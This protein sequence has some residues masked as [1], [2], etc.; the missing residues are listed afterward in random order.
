MRSPFVSRTA[1]HLR[2]CWTLH[3]ISVSST[4]DARNKCKKQMET[5]FERTENWN[6]CGVYLITSFNS[7][8]FLRLSTIISIIL[9]LM[10]SK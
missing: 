3:K 5:T 2:V 1:A 8:L 10:L 7:T 9:L 4:E 6:L